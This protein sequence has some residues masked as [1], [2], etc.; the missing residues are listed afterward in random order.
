MSHLSLV[1][2][3]KRR[4]EAPPAGTSAPL[5]AVAQR[6]L[7]GEERAVG[8]LLAAVLPAVR[9]ACKALLGSSHR[10]LDDAV[11][12]AL[13]A[14]HRALVNYRFECSVLHYAVRITFRTT[15][16]YRR[17]LRLLADRFLLVADDRELNDVLAPLPADAAVMAERSEALRRLITKLPSAQ[18]EA[19]LLHV[20]LEY[21]IAEVAAI[22]GVSVDTIKTRLKLGKDSLR[23]RIER[24]R[25]LG[26]I[27][28]GKP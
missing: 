12:N 22:N 26:S 16:G 8:E 19:L 13:I 3:V 10:E 23:R 27:L 5:D 15:H 2:Q 9:S 14:F 6:A 25:A 20:A 11:Q 1:R 4:P 28:G 7:E 21:P 18:A 17:R 24:D